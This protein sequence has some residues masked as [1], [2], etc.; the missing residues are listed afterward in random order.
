M[1]FVESSESNQLDPTQLSLW[2]GKYAVRL[3]AFVF[4]LLRNRSLSEDV[5]Q[6]T[7]A[8]A[9]QAGGGIR[10]GAEKAWLFQVAFHEAMLVRRKTGVH[11]RAEDEFRIRA[12]QDNT[13][14]KTET[15]AIDQLL[16]A[17]VVAEVRTA[18]QRL[19][20]E[21]QEVVRRRIYQEQTF[22]EIATELNIPLGTALTRMRIAL[23]QLRRTFKNHDEHSP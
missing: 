20:P 8:K 13:P 15:A 10:P 7:F 17:E 2:Y 19:S 22:Q 21:L 1:L 3:N 6:V 11:K 4:G 14:F 9:L 16:T 5:V 12:Q 23:E 18:M